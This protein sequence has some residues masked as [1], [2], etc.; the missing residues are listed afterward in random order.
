MTLLRQQLDHC[1]FERYRALHRKRGRANEIIGACMSTP[2]TSK[3]Q[4]HEE[5]LATANIFNVS[6][7]RSATQSA[8]DLFRRSG[9]SSIHW[10]AE[11]S[12]VDY[13][14][15]VAGREDEPNF[16]AEILSPVFQAF[17]AVGDA[18]IPA[19]Y[20]PLSAGYPRAK[21]FAFHRPTDA[22]IRSARI[23]FGTR[24]FVPFERVMYWS[25]F[26]QKPPALTDISDAEL[27]RFH[28]CHHDQ[29]ATHFKSSANFL[30]LSLEGKG[31]GSRLCEFCGLPPIPLRVVDWAMGHDL[32]ARPE[33][34]DAK[35]CE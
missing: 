14:S 24:T 26:T 16:V 12:G 2:T 8:H 7:H 29:I 3:S 10:P 17:V 31:L 32:T 5:A 11:V 25:H 30:M 15:K 27:A 22:W 34:L 9:V 18:P 13:Q 1:R 28:E 33:S 23:H 4:E 35:V 19:L 21:F 6:L 20:G